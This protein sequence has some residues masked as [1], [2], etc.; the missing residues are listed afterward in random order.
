MRKGEQ[1]RKIDNNL[2][3]N[4]NVILF[5]NSSNIL[6]VGVVEQMT[7]DAVKI[8]GD[9]FARSKCIGYNEIPKEQGV[10]SQVDMQY[11]EQDWMLK[12]QRSNHES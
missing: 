10:F 9:W 1:M 5:D 7:T 6:A 4:D 2:T 11:I 12:S 8:D 3:V